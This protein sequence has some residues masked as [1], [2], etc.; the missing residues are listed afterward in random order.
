MVKVMEN[1]SVPVIPGLTPNPAQPDT[2]GFL[3][4][5]E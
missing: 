5:Q 2:T 3:P 1:L 4:S